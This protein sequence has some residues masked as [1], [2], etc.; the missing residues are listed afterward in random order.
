M[1]TALFN[2]K[3]WQLSTVI[4]SH[5]YVPFCKIICFDFDHDLDQV[6]VCLPFGAKQLPEHFLRIVNWTTSVEQ[7]RY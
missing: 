4:V 1:V 3:Y 6:K 5:V 7:D 2:F